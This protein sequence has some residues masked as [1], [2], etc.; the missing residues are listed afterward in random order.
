MFGVN[1]GLDEPMSS[2]R[3]ARLEEGLEVLDLIMA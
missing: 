3:T 1:K 2:I